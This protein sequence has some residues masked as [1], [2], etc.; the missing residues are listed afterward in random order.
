VLDDGRPVEITVFDNKSQPI[1][2]VV[3]IDTSGSMWPHMALIRRAASAFA[4]TFD[5]RDRARIGGF[6]SE[7]IGLSA[8][9]TRDPDELRSVLQN[10]LWPGSFS[11]VWNALSAGTAAMADEP[12]R[13]VVLALTDGDNKGSVPG[14]G[15][16]GDVRNR[17]TRDGFMVYV[18]SPP[19]ITLGSDIK[20]LAEESG[21]GYL[22][23]AAHADL[24]AAAKEVAAELHHQYL[25]GFVPQK[26]DGRTHVI[27]VRTKKPNLKVSARTK[28]LAGVK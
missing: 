24:E 5:E 12:G 2:A 27:E 8:R 21:G 10:E 23:L 6:S 4:A 19:E 9:W 14:F 22:E 18:I 17:V 16:L 26:L 15:G 1:T 25:I 13:R 7:Q 28:Y 3:M 20:E 11:P